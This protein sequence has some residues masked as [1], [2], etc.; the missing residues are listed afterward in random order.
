MTS[1]GVNNIKNYSFYK[2]D[3]YEKQLFWMILLVLIN[4]VKIENVYL[5]WILM[6]LIINQLVL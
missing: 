6:K 4:I 1:R 3:K 5:H 2:T